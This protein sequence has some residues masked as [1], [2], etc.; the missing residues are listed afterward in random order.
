MAETILVADPHFRAAKAIT[1]LLETQAGFSVV[2]IAHDRTSAAR[3]LRR[4]RPSVLLVDIG[5]LDPGH[6]QLPLLH[7]AS[8]GTRLLLMGMDD[9]PTSNGEVRRLGAERYVRK[10]APLE[11]WVRALRGDGCPDAQPV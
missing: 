4:H 6:S 3:L 9:V 2:A 1:R 5:I 11:A 7:Q 8:P 10:D